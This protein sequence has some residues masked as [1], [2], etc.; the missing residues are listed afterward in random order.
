LGGAAVFL[1]LT[2]VTSLIALVGGGLRLISASGI[3]RA[4]RFWAKATHWAAG[5][6]V[7]VE[8]AENLPAEPG[9]VLAANHQG[10]F[11]ILAVY[12]LPVEF[13]WLAKESLFHIF[14]MGPAM[15]RAG[16]LPVVRGDSSKTP[17]L[18]KAAARAIRAG[19]NV[20]VFPEGTRNK[21]PQAGLLPFKRGGFVLARLAKRPVVPVGIVGTFEV[22]DAKP[23]RVRPRPITLR[24]GRPLS[25]EAF[26]A[27]LEGFA[28][29]T[30]KA[31]AELAG[32]KAEG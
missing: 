32:R 15:G 17:G 2:L 27:D 7:T 19:T 29:A 25:P 12:A 13:R 9:Y 18:L 22:L 11:D 4:S 16:H 30:R 26:G 6:P 21:N 1:G 8:G 31:V 20:V 10:V 24:I 14:L 3:H 5:A 28:A 23:L